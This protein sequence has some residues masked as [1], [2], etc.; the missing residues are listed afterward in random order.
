MTDFLVQHFW[1][2]DA[3]NLVHLQFK[4]SVKLYFQI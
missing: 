2:H 1:V 3:F 4:G